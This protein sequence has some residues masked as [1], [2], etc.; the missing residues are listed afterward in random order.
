MFLNL[1]GLAAPVPID[2]VI[3]QNPHKAGRYLAV[4]G[5]VV[6]PPSHLVANP[7]SE[8]VVMNDIYLGEIRARLATIGSTARVATV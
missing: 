4:S 3:D 2:F 6:M 7:V 1:L 5:Q 8:I